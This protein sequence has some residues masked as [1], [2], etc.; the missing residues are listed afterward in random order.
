[1]IRTP[2][3]L[4]VTSVTAQ[5][6]VPSLA[7]AYL[8]A[9]LKKAGHGVTYI[10][11]VGERLGTGRD[12]G[13]PGLILNGLAIPEILERLPAQCDVIG[14]S[15]L[16]SNDWIYARKILDALHAARPG[17]TI[18]VGGE[19]VTGDFET[20]L[21]HCPFIR[22]CVLG[23]GEDAIV[24]VLEALGD[25]GGLS[26]IPGVAYL[27]SSGKIV[28]TARRTRIS[29]VDNIAW[30]DWESVPLTPYLDAGLGMAI[31][32]VRSMP[33]IG[34]RGCPY[35]CTFCSSPQMWDIAWKPRRD[36]DRVLAE[37]KS[38]IRTYGID[39]LE[40][41]DMSPSIDR[42]WLESFCDAVG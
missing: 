4:P 28:K 17:A 35:R 29:D 42:R 22:C 37:A 6:G 10:D 36:L 2:T 14:V 18:I 40:F 30:P 5:Q 26:R 16:F 7:L 24:E 19:H 33:M 8:G 13:E 3:V 23:E 12:F 20:V 32:G 15:C 31:Q 9:A 41:Y 39:H 1:L 27:D 34:S 21:K 25:P 38:Y 11:S